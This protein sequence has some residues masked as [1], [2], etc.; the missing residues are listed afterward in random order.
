MRTP[1]KY[2]WL[3]IV[4]LGVCLVIV[5]AHAVNNKPEPSPVKPTPVQPVQ[6]QP[7]PQDLCPAP[8]VV[9]NEHCQDPPVTPDPEPQPD[10]N[11]V[12]K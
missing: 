3:V 12:G 11:F 10:P 1:N 5:A 2:G 9:I 6:P 8:K 4:F 7:K